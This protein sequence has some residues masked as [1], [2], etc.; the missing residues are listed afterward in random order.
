ML[1]IFLCADLMFAS[2]V[3]GAAKTLQ[4]PLKIVP[5]AADAGRSLTAETRL[6]IVD[7]TMPGL[8]LA[9]AVATI[10]EHSPSARIVAFGPH[11]D[12]AALGA[13]REAGCDVLTRGQFQQNYAA[14]L[15][16]VQTA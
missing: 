8:D 5:V 4:V 15:Q 11:V 16:S 6:V 13:A 7:L 14:L 9:Q 12:E 1:C 3:L 2:R 10:R